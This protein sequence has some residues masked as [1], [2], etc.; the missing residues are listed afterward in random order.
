MVAVLSGPGATAPES[1]LHFTQIGSSGHAFAALLARET[2]YRVPASD[3]LAVDDGSNDDQAHKNC[4]GQ[5][6]RSQN[7]FKHSAQ[8]LGRHGKT[9]PGNY[10]RLWH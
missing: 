2:S 5:G 10:F 7:A 6:S 4:A 9:S 1:C 3:V 8:D